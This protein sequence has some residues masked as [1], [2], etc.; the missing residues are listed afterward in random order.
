M[1]QKKEPEETKNPAEQVEP[2][3]EGKRVRVK[4]PLD[5]K[6]KSPVF[7]CVNGEGCTIQR[8]KWVEVKPYI[9]E[10]IKTGLAQRENVEVMIETLADGE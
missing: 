6:D 4:I 7:V 2:T 10:V 1:A 8:G 5:R 3:E 9:A